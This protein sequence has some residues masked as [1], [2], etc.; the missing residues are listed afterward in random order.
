M[1]F[2]FDLYLKLKSDY[3]NAVKNNKEQFTF[4]GHELLTDY[5]K[6]MIE[7]LESKFEK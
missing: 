2:T 1:T 5:A 4:E 6:Y 7:Y 3:S